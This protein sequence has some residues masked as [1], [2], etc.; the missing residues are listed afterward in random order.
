MK[1]FL[2]E[3]TILSVVDFQNSEKTLLGKFLFGFVIKD[4]TNR[5][6]PNFR[7]ITSTIK[8]QNLF[9]FITKSGSCYVI[10]DDPTNL[11]ITFAEFVVMR[12]RLYSPDDILELRLLLNHNDDRTIH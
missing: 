2:K 11:D 10:N 9:E 5:F 6:E 4:E 3:A 12:E 1:T 8:T 7:V